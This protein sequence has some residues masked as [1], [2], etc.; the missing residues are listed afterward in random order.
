MS[1]RRPRTKA[2]PAPTVAGAQFDKPKCER[3]PADEFMRE[4]RDMMRAMTE[5]MGSFMGAQRESRS[6][7]KSPKR[8]SGS[9]RSGSRKPPSPA[10]WQK[11]SA[12]GEEERQRSP[13]TASN[14]SEAVVGQS[15]PAI[16]AGEAE[17]R[18]WLQVNVAGFRIRVLY[19]PRAS[20]TVMGPIGLQLPNA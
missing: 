5:Q 9:A 18:W 15:S 16:P 20:R 2:P 6:K 14:E 1:G 13:S 10:A 7:R 17:V 11:A 4:I 3:A 12:G 19:D 8:R